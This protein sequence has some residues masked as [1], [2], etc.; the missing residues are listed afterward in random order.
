MSLGAVA[1]VVALVTLLFGFGLRR[2]PTI[3]R[4]ALIGRPAPNFDL[5]MLNGGQRGLGS[6]GGRTVSL[7]SFRGQVLVLNFW[8][9]WCADCRV[10]HPSLAAAWKRY[11]DR[12][13]VLLG[14]AFQD[15]PS[16]SRAYVAE[17]GGDWPQLTD[18]GSRTALAYGVY[19]VPETFVIG[20]DGRVAYK[21]IGPI[22]YERLSQQITR[23]LPEAS[24]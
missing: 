18:P 2:D 13:M 11:R 22:S 8:A 1:A 9:S 10:E 17:L 24:S 19:G 16:S 3:I 21:A 6:Q 23:L 12:G 14:I 5:A 7:S 15:Q 20:P 4:S